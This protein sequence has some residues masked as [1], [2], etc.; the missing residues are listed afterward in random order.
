[1]RLISPHMVDN[2]LNTKKNLFRIKC[3]LSA[4]NVVFL[5]LKQVDLTQAVASAP[6]MIKSFISCL[7]MKSAK[8]SLVRA[9]PLDLIKMFSDTIFI[10]GTSSAPTVSGLNVGVPADKL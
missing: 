2:D 3:R 10:S 1:M 9:L 5:I 7:L 6:A 8:A 4:M